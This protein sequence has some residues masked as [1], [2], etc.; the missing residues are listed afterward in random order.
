M[1]DYL[2]AFEVTEA[3]AEEMDKGS[4]PGAL[5]RVTVPLDDGKVRFHWYTDLDAEGSTSVRPLFR[6]CGDMG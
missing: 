5:H 6:C 3:V 1:A 4:A 2:F